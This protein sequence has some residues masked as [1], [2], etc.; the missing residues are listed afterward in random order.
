[1]GRYQHRP[2]FAYIL[3]LAFLIQISKYLEAKTIIQTTA[4]NGG[5]MLTISS[6]DLAGFHKSMEDQ[7][8]SSATVSKYLH[9]VSVFLKYAGGE[10]QDRAHLN[11]FRKYL[12]DS[13]YTARSINSMLAA[14]NK[15]LEYLGV[16]WRLRY[17][18]VQRQTF[19]P[20]EKELSKEEYFHLIEKAEAA[21]NRRLSL[22]I[23]TLCALGIRVSELQAI[24]VESLERKE[25]IIQNKGKI[26]TILIPEG[27]VEKL[28]TYCVGKQIT[29]GQIFITRSGKP[30]DRSNIWKMIKRLGQVAKVALQKV[31]PHNLRHLFART[32]YKLFPDPLHL[33]DILGHSSVETTRIYTAH[34]G[35]EER[36][37]I[38]QLGLF[39]Q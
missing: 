37:Q 18:K 26:R 36:R 22:L 2:I 30:M 8:F 11:G 24:T 20:P 28:R 10:I 6:N 39:L 25:A 3:M 23:Q 32:Y 35:Q 16:D 7:E 17:E 29:S 1:M 27:L 33:A 4:E 5:Y 21:G 9:D 14:V 13:G 15:F 34:S 31:F 38:A 12:A 19:L